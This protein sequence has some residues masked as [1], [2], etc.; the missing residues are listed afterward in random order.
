[1]KRQIEAP[2]AQVAAGN[3][4]DRPM[5]QWTWQLVLAERIQQIMKALLHHRVRPGARAAHPRLVC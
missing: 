3:T 4:Y 1:V 2:R 5:S